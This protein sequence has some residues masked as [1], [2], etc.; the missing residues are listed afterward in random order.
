MN[1]L[2]PFIKAIITFNVGLWL[3]AAYASRKTWHE[4]FQE[5]K[6]KRRIRRLEQDE[7]I[8]TPE[9][10][11][12]W[13]E[14]GGFAVQI[15]NI[16]EFMGV[17]RR[18]FEL[19]VTWRFNNS[20]LTRDEAKELVLRLGEDKEYFFLMFRL[21]PANGVYMQPLLGKQEFYSMHFTGKIQRSVRFQEF[22][23]IVK[24]PAEIYESFNIDG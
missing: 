23:K 16:D 4:L 7:T 14:K 12:Y 21:S 22:C 5:W 15:E 19:G 20:E 6:K 17:Q 8:M 3:A 2:D 10:F 11:Q 13:I 24:R 1:E 18:A 9:K